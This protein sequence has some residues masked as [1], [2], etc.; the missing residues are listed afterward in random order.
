MITTFTRNDLLRYL[1]DE[2]PNR[3][4]EEMISAQLADGE[5]EQETD[6]L[7]HSKSLVEGFVLKAR[8][9]VV[10]TILAYSRNY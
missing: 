4:R 9:D 10:D 6:E 3:E 7:K 2:L 1:Y 5:L 8:Q